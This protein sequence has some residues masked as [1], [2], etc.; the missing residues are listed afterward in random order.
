V[1]WRVGTKLGGSKVGD[2]KISI[3]DVASEQVGRDV[4]TAVSGGCR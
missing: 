4:G 2:L 1:G 3:D